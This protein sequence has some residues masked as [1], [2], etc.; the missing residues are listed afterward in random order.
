MKKNFLKLKRKQIDTILSAGQETLSRIGLTKG[1]LKEIR[2]SLGM[3]AEQAALRAGVSQQTWTKGEDNEVKGSISLS[4]LRRYA[5]ALDCSLKY[6][7]VPNSGSLEAAVEKRAFKLAKEL[8]E[9]THTTMSLENQAV[10]SQERERLTEELARQLTTELGN[11]FWRDA[12][13]I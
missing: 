1:W 7:L 3:T 12:D 8:I 4:T 2:V 10:T 5:I 6:A 9:R 13:G 11:T